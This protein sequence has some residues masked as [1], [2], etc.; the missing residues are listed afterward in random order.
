MTC[1]ISLQSLDNT[2]TININ[3]YHSFH[4][5]SFLTYIDTVDLHIDIRNA[6]EEEWIMTAMTDTYPNGNIRLRNP[7]TNL[8]FSQKEL[9]VI[10]Q[11]YHNQGI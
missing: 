5:S 6:S 10:Y 9:I 3:E 11:R 1:P 7:I 8:P 2:C 4:I